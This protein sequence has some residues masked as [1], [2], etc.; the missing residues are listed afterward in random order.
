MVDRAVWPFRV[1]IFLDERR[2]LVINRMRQRLRLRLAVP[3]RDQAP[4]FFFCGSIEKEAQRVF[5]VTQ[6]VLRSSSHN[7]AIAGVRGPLDYLLRD[8]DNTVG[9]EH[10]HRNSPAALIT[11]ERERLQQTVIQ[12]IATLFL[13]L[14][15][16]LV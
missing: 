8:F 5:S 13:L 10:L 1:E 3:L 11:S 14:D 16:R 9:V 6:E 12:R 4:H 2:T 15:R 7:Y